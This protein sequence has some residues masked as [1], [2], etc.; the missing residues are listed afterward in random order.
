LWFLALPKASRTFPTDSQLRLG[1][2]FILT[3]RG[4]DDFALTAT[5]QEPGRL[6]QQVKRDPGQISA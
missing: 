5:L 4:F 1:G 3:S 6:G 2:A